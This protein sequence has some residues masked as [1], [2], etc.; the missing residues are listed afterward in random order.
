MNHG[1]FRHETRGGWAQGI[2]AGS[3]PACYDDTRAPESWTERV[4][5]SSRLVYD[6]GADYVIAE[7]VLPR[8]SAPNPSL[9]RKATAGIS[10]A[11]HV[12]WRRVRRT[13]RVSD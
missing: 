8:I 3:A 7:A 9:L 4:V 11:A 13:R 10:R 6:T 1:R 2:V 12:A 5:D